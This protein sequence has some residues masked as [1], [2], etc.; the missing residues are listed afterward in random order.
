LFGVNNKY[1]FLQSGKFT[2]YSSNGTKLND[3]S[4]VGNPSGFSAGQKQFI[5][6]NN[7]V[8]FQDYNNN[9]LNIYTK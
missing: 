5:V 7:K 8:V 4:F 6:V 9:K 3:Y 2:E 1:Y